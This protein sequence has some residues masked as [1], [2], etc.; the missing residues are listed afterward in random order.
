MRPVRFVKSA[1]AAT[2]AL[3]RASHLKALEWLHNCTR[4][5]VAACPLRF[6]AASFVSLVIAIPAMVSIG[7]PRDIDYYLDEVS[8]EDAIEYYGQDAQGEV[9][10][11]LAA[12]HGLSGPIDRAQAES[13][14]A[15]RWPDT[16][17][18][19]TE[20]SLKRPFFDLTISPP[21]SVSILWAAADPADRDQFPR[22]EDGVVR[23]RRPRSSS[24]QYPDAD[25]RGPPGSAFT[26][27][28][29]RFLRTWRPLGFR[30]PPER[31]A[32]ARKVSKR[33]LPEAEIPTCRLSQ[34]GGRALSD[35]CRRS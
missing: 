9:S 29:Q 25:D 16:G 11:R 30:L 26:R 13:L 3:L 23:A 2:V 32:L 15:L 10:G 5:A 24:V 12:A 19:I 27:R 35:T 18:R 22:G 6:R 20:R 31:P 8:V 28:E 17:E 14:A 7:R 21:K 34:A 4:R 1:L 33:G